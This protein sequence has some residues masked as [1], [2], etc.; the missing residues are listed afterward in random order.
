MVTNVSEKQ[1]VSNNHEQSHNKE[2]S[3][4]EYEKH[5]ERLRDQLEKAEREHKEKGS[6]VQETI[7]EAKELAEEHE[8]QD[9]RMPSPAERRRGPLSKKQLDNSFASQMS[10]TRE[11]LGPAGRAFSRFIHA[12]PVEAASEFLASTIARPNSL[13]AGS[14]AAFLAVTV[15]YLV[16]NYYGFKLSGF[17]T[18]AA[19]VIGWI[20]GTI[21][22]YVLVAFRGRQQ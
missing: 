21:Y 6:N 22:D 8:K 15:L 19:F 18:I 20:L 2:I 3:R 4:D 17:E 16:A 12:K 10:H 1:A 13:L 11:H 9:I 7:K 5:A 14:I